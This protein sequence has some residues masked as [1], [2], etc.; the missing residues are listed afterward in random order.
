L[1]RLTFISASEIMETAGATRTQYPTQRFTSSWSIAGYFAAAALLIHLLTNSRY[2]YFRD[3]LY[4]IACSE[5]LDWG[6][7]DFAPLIAVILRGTRELLGDSLQAIRLPVA[8][9]GSARILL[10]G[11]LAHELGGKRTAVAL[12]CLCAFISLGADYRLSMNSFEPLF[13]MGC[14]Y[15]LIRIIKGADPRLFL[16]FGVLAGLGL[17]NK[18]SAAFFLISL[19]AALVFSRHRQL[20]A[21]RWPWLAMLLAAL[22]FLPN[23]LWQYQHGW[24]TFEALSNA[25]STGKNVV[26]PPIRFLYEQVR[27]LNPFAALI[28]IPGVVALL[29][30]ARFQQYRVLGLMYLVFLPLMMAFKAKNY[31]LLPI[32]PVLFAAGAVAW[33]AW[34]RERPRFAWAKW[35]LAIAIF[36]RW[37]IY[38]PVSLPI[39]PPETLVRYM[40]GLGVKPVRN[41]V[42]HVGLLPQSLG[43]QFGWREMVIAVAQVY[44]SL[45]EEDRIKA[46]ILAGNYGEAGAIDLFGPQ[47]SLPNAIS[48]HQNYFLWGPRQ[49]TGEVLILL[50]A[51]MA[52]AQKHCVTV[53]EGPTLAPRF[54]M[55]EE[56]YTILICRGLKAPLSQTWPKLKNWN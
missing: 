35:V 40:D 15:I 1:L 12:A 54:G 37:A 6:Y 16:G 21:T 25:Q 42:G 27:M 11:L 36:A 52:D 10:T 44:H 46:G 32:Y 43:D 20:Y 29:V 13:W 19:G 7:V 24:P 51:D 38:V 41:E 4:F 14:V 50:Q 33:E 5:R 18:H 45:P 47:Y 23:V 9:A 30:S 3:E 55:A 8:L 53:D 34:L 56:H 39:L 48:G 17:Q 28:W 31:Y 49:Y 26:V 2:S 22:I